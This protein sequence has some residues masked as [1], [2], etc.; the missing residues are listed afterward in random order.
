MVLSGLILALA[1]PAQT[2]TAFWFVAPEAQEMHGDRPIYLRITTL[3]QLAHVKISMPA[4]PLFT[5]IQIT[6]QGNSNYSLDLTPWIDMLENKPWDVVLNKGLYIK[7]STPI[8]AY[9]EI[10]TYCQ[11]NPE[12][13]AL[14]GK[15]AKGKIFYTPFQTHFSR[16]GPGY[17]SVINIVSTEDNNLITI[18]PSVDLVNHP[19]GIPFTIT[20]N[21]G[22]TI[23][24]VAAGYYGI[25]NPMGTKITSTK[26]ICVTVSEDSD[27]GPGGCADI[28]GDQLVPVTLL[29]KDYIIPKGFLFYEEFVYF[30]AVEDDTE[31]FLEGNTV[32]SYVISHGQYIK[33]PVS[34][35]FIM[36]SSKPVYVYHV[37]GHGCELG[38]AL[39][40][41][42]EC[43]GSMKIGFTRS[44]SEYFNLY[45]MTHNGNQNSFTLNGNQGIINSSAFTPIA[46]TNGEWVFANISF[47]NSQIPPGVGQIIENTAGLFHMGL[48]NGGAYSGCRYGYFS[49]F[50]SLN[51]GEDIT[52]CMGDSVVLDASINMAPYLW[53]TGDTTQAIVVTTPGVYWV[54]AGGGPCQLSDTITVNFE[55]VPSI[56]LGNDTVFP[57]GILS[58]QLQAPLGPFSYQWNIPDSTGSTLT[59]DQNG[60]Y[61]CKVTSS[62]GCEAMDTIQ[63][64]FRTMPRDINT[65]Y[66]LPSLDTGMACYYPFDGNA[67]DLS[68]N[69]NHGTLLGPIPAPDRHNLPGGALNFAGFFNPQK[70]VVPASPSLVFDSTATFSYWFRL[71]SFAGMN[72]TGHFT[73][74]G[75]H[76]IFSKNWDSNTLY[77]GISVAQNY[78]LSAQIQSNGW[79]SGIGGLCIIPNSDTGRWVHMV[80]V[81][82]PDRLK[83]YVNG[84]LCNTFFG[85]TTFANSS[86]RALIFGMLEVYWYPLNGRLDETRFYYR[87]LTDQEVWALYSDGLM[88]KGI[89]E[90]DTICRGTTATLRLINPQPG[91]GYALQVNSTDVSPLMFGSSDTLTFTSP[92]LMQNSVLTLKAVDTTSGCDLILDSAWMVH[93]ISPLASISTPAGICLGDTAQL[94]AT[95][96]NFYLWSTGSTTSSIY[97][98][99]VVSTVYSVIAYDNLGCSDT[100][101]ALLNVWPLPVVQASS[102]SPVCEN[103]T[104]ELT[105]TGGITYLWSGPGGFSSNA[106]NPSIPNVS[107]LNA[108][109]YQVAVTDTNA[110]DNTDS[111]LV[112]I[113]S[114]V[115]DTVYA[116]FCEGEFYILPTGDTVF[117]AGIYTS[118][119]SSPQACDTVIT[120]YINVFPLPQMTSWSNSPVC[121]GDTLILAATGYDLT[122]SWTGPGGFISNSPTLTFNNVGVA[123]GGMYLVTGTD[124]NGCQDTDTLWV[125]IYFI[126]PTIENIS[127][128]DGQTYQLPGGTI[129]S[130][131]GVW[132]DTLV[133]QQGC[134]SVLITNITVHPL[135]QVSIAGNAPLCE[136][137]D[138]QLAA[139]GGNFYTWYL[140][141]HDTIHKASFTISQVNLFDNGWYKV[142][143]M[144]TN[145]CRSA[146]SVFI[147]I[148]PLSFTYLT[149]SACPGL[150]YQLPGGQ[151]VTPPGLFI[152]SLIS[153]HGCDSILYIEILPR[154]SPDL[155]ITSNSPVCIG[156]NIQLLAQSNA[157][158]LWEGPGIFQVNVP[159]P[160]VNNAQLSDSGWYTA[161]ATGPNGC[162]TRDSVLVIVYSCEGFDNL[163]ENL[164]L[165]ARPVPFNDILFIDIFVSY[166]FRPI[167][168]RLEDIFGRIILKKS[169]ELGEISSQS[170]AFITE[171]LSPGI[172]IV[173]ILH[174]EFTKEIKVIKIKN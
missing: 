103:H 135:P 42:I 95:G 169:L 51:L 128:C 96:G 43:T 94:T 100:V 79:Y 26:P 73:P 118:I 164:Q 44:T 70:V 113:L 124:P 102:N 33:H 119:I 160:I 65:R 104:L 29:G 76:I 15:N 115:Y 46:G 88:M 148:Y 87:P 72:G 80:Y 155:A 150:P 59:V 52:A 84:E 137:D 2:D 172:Y 21:K 152:D 5:P 171:H 62:A 147:I 74:Q 123:Q 64:T 63:I 111:T 66:W 57:C 34:S 49:S 98:A 130:T 19:S 120:T 157:P 30:L 67:M 136:G 12:I 61:W 106:Q 132:N 101:S 39:L 174:S 68:G 133:S 170:I 109:W 142:V 14:K 166:P 81:Y 86:N 18:T 112:S 54:Q 125:T 85:Q 45:L 27:W 78:E 134:D 50:N 116:S 38:S 141:S 138:L 161:I 117:V 159:N 82:Y 48:I 3:E 168:V 143:V 6:I 126:P 10:S 11:C 1:S 91:I 127:L 55:A 58:A 122:F 89:L 167:E 23:A 165:T 114:S 99:P 9:Y 173:K 90:T 156:H 140:P 13:F 121:A 131:G 24:L 53:N 158:I 16:V 36:H 40:P 97:V 25:S 8:S 153:L 69:N 93:V 28:L 145:F 146:D 110:C 154:K 139:S 20:L 41:A 75:Y 108:G 56:N 4:E 7:S 151:W 144:D 31:I 32:P 47:D 17:E 22:Q 71:N 77:S 92:P 37:T 60:T 163:A 83:I 149:D 129:V 162:I 107:L 35:P 105:A